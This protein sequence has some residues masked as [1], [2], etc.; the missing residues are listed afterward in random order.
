MPLAIVFARVALVIGLIIAKENVAVAHDEITELRM[1]AI[2]LFYVV[3]NSQSFIA[4]KEITATRD[5]DLGAARNVLIDVKDIFDYKQAADLN[6]L[7]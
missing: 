5:D 4:L 6:Y 2:K 3:R 1:E 7:Y